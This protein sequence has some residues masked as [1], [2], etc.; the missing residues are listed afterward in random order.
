LLKAAYPAIK[1]VQPNS[2]VVAAGLSRLVGDDSPP[3]FMEQMYAAG[4]KG[5]FDAAAAHPYVF[6]GGLAADQDNGWSDVGRLRAV[7]DSHGDGGKKIWMTELGAATSDPSAEGITQLEQA[8]QIADVLAAAAATG[9]SGPAFIYSIR[10]VSSSKRND[11][12]SNF[13]ALLTTDWQPKAAAA[14]L[15]R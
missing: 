15:A 13:G 11:R 6:P 14:A 5:F 2:T 10:D 1:A 12:E 8:K 7:M 3:A 9:F 4:A